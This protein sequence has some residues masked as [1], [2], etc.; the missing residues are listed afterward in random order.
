M[1]LGMDEELNAHDMFEGIL[2]IFTQGQIQ[3]GAK[4]G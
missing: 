3:G 2:A 1:K 4:I